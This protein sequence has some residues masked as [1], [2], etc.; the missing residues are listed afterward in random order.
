MKPGVV[1]TIESCDIPIGIPNETPNETPG[2]IP[3]ETMNEN[4]NGNVNK[5]SNEDVNQNTNEIESWNKKPKP[6]MTTDIKEDE[7][8]Q[9]IKSLEMEMYVHF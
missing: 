6:M 9:Y 8:Q 5:I 1:P 7:L 2:E 4:S 3:N